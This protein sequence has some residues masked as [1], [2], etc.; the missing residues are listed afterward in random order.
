MGK[1]KWL[2]VLEAIYQN[3]EYWKMNQSSLEDLSNELGIEKDDVDAV[4]DS[5]QA[6]D[7]I[8]RDIEQVELT[9]RG[10]DVINDR[11]NK[12]EQ[13]LTDRLLLIFTT[14][15]TLGVTVITAETLLKFENPVVTLS[16]YAIFAI[17]FI[18]LGILA[19]RRYRI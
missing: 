1:E 4:L 6:Q 8:K 13:L 3:N 14:V 12:E 7:L 11:K 19:D 18:V 9:Q 2:D 15:L 10:F 16:Y 17:V 5:L